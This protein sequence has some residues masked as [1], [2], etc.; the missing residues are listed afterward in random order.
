MKG[1]KQK[2]EYKNREREHGKP[3]GTEA[4]SQEAERRR[5]APEKQ[6]RG[7]AGKS[8]KEETEAE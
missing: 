4:E 8:G 7:E 2:A 3:G 6:L 5:G 1:N